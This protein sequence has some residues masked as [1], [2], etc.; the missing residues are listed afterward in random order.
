MLIKLTDIQYIFEYLVIIYILF[1]QRTN[2]ISN[3]PTPPRN[4]FPSQGPKPQ[5]ISKQQGPPL[6]TPINRG[7]NNWKEKRSKYAPLRLTPIDTSSSKLSS[8]IIYTYLH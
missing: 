4:S 3:L 2:W 6:L 7:A 1:Y 8:V 5:D